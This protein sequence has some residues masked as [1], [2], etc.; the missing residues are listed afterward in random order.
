MKNFLLPF[1]IL[2]FLN[3]S[4]AQNPFITV[5]KTDN[6]GSSSNNRILIPTFGNGYN[7]NIEWEDTSNV[8]I[9]GS[10][11][12]LTNTN[13]LT[14]IFPSPGVYRVKISGDF[15]RIFFQNWGDRE[16]IIN[17]E[18]WGNIIWGNMENA[19]WGCSNLNVTATDVLTLPSN[20]Q[21]MFKSCSSLVGNPSFNNWNTNNVTNMREMFSQASL[22]N[23]PIGNW[24]TQ[25]ATNM[26]EMF[27]RAT[28][29][30]QPINNWNTQ[31]VT[32]MEG[33]FQNAA[34]FNQDIGTWILNPNVVL[35]R[36]FDINGMDCLN[37]SNTLIG[38]EQNNPNVT[39]K[40]LGVTSKLYH[41]NAAQL[42]RSSL[43]Q[44]GWIINGDAIIQN[45]P[46]NPFVTVWKT[47]N[48][49]PSANNQ[50]MIPISS[51]GYNFN[52][53]WEDTLNPSINGSIQNIINL[54]TTSTLSHTLT[55]PSPG[56][57][58][59]K[60]TGSF[61]RICFFFGG[62][63]N[64]ILDVEQWGDISWSSMEDAFYKCYL[65]NVS[66]TDVLNLPPNCSRMFSG[67][68]TLIGNPSFNN[69]NTSNVTN[70][71]K[72]FS[73]VKYFNQ[74]IGNWNTSN[75][76]NMRDMFDGVTY[77]N[78]DISSWNTSNVT[79]MGGMFFRA[80]SFNQDIGNWNTQNV[81]NMSRMFYGASSFNQPIGNWN[82]SNVTNMFRMFRGA[83]TFNQPIGNWNTSNVTDMAE[84]FRGA[85]SF[86]QDIGNWN[87]SNVTDMGSMFA[88]AT[89]F[90]QPIGNWNTSNVTSMAGMFW[91]A[92][93]F[94]QPIGNWNTDN[95]VLLGSMFLY[96]TS[97]N[98]DIGNWN[99]SNVTNMFRVFYGATSFNQDISNWN[100][101]NVNNMG[102]MFANAT[103][104]NCNISNW[105]VSNVTTWGLYHGFTEM[106]QNAKNFN[107]DL[108]SWNMSNARLTNNMF[109]N[110]GLSVCNLDRII[111]HWS[112]QNL[113][114]GLNFGIQGLTYS[115]STQNHI[116]TLI[117]QHNW[118]VVGGQTLPALS[119]INLS[120]L[121]T[122]N[123]SDASVEI[124]FPNFKADT[125][126]YLTLSGATNRIDTS[127]NQINL[128]NLNA[129]NHQ[130]IISDD[131]VC[132]VYTE[133]FTINS[134][135][136]VPVI[137]SISVK[138]IDCQGQDFGEVTL[139]ASSVNGGLSAEWTLD[140]NTISNSLS[141]DSL[142]VGTYIVN[143]IDS[144]GCQLQESITIM[145]PP[146]ISIDVLNINNATCF[147]HN[148][149]FIEVMANG[150]TGEL[151]YSWTDG[152]QILAD[153]NYI[154]NLT[155]ESYIL[156]IID[157][158]GCT[159]TDTFIITQPNEIQI[160]NII[161]SDVTCFGEN[162]GSI[163]FQV[164][165]GVG[166]YNYNWN[167][168]IFT[169]TNQNDL[170]PGNYEV[171]V[172][173]ANGCVNSEIFNINQPDEIIISNIVTNDLT[174]FGGSDGS[175][176]FQVAGGVGSYNYNWIPNTFTGTN[177]NDLVAGNYSVVIEDVDGCQ[178]SETFSINQ[179]DEIQITNLMLSDVTCFGE[180]DGS[181]SFQ[182]TGGAG[183]YNYNWNPSIFT[184]TNQ[185]DLVPG[186]YEVVVEDANGCVNSEIF[187]I[188]QPDEI[189]ISNIL[190][191]DV[192][193]FGE[194]DGSISFQATGGVGSY[195]YNWIPNIFTGT[196]QNNL[197]SGN[198]EVV[199]E[200]ANGCLKSE[201]FSINQPDEIQINYNVTDNAIS[202]SVS[203]GIS[204]Y[205]FNWTGPDNFTA[206]TA[207]IDNL[208]NG[209]YN[210]VVTDFNGCEQ[211]IQINIDFDTNAPFYLNSK[212][213]S[214]YP[215]PAKNF[216]NIDLNQNIDKVNIIITDL[217]GKTVFNQDFENMSSEKINLENLAN[218]IYT[219]RISDSELNN[220]N[221]K[222]IKN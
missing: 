67:C 12:N 101:S 94:N 103:S 76:T 135:I 198:Y 134:N 182:V 158:L 10:L 13:G 1:F 178:K 210:L 122:C 32:N 177:Q 70:M 184:G 8:N 78:Q 104:F 24:N 77:F 64:K 107:Q 21:A 54:T 48:L 160:N 172:E 116:N 152:N 220:F 87:T 75:V 72:M 206:N 209:D 96:A 108:S 90:N 133:N 113:F 183:S 200:D 3:N 23:Q 6:W 5:W 163:S 18:Q 140:G 25:N 7:F 36:I 148:D 149:G 189:I 167:P 39:N 53:Y 73:E 28:L 43:I 11:S 129:G 100:T 131:G 68:E 188:N 157:S 121:N 56:V 74:P 92:A 168:S 146:S 22:F 41:G 196:N 102:Q 117:N 154:E 173:D 217:Y 125:T 127:T 218:G 26:R 162:D 115:D 211:T 17:I 138:N 79:D 105:D 4:F 132:P 187:T 85:T 159:K 60:I 197:V 110:S 180:N 106:F 151:Y 119:N 136:S 219:L 144:S 71:S 204:P 65:L 174:C 35:N 202:V 82:T 57:Y 192:T 51:S 118:T 143:L 42:A 112:Q 40:V 214:I 33:M 179:P 38:L 15:P 126:Y 91:S 190:T 19:F 166:S 221:Y 142:E 49:G 44:R 165:G 147:G 89:S 120:S 97:F 99:T 114:Q 66:A 124:S 98:Q 145:L 30:N 222:I 216:I 86:N 215:N 212:N 93:S 205:D 27:F 175:I 130:L 20:C 55:F 47:D 109:E 176:S 164:T 170:V 58:R 155:A 153:S 69:W 111:Y 191:N 2:L 185:N 95:L 181:I 50:I 88:G 59:V 52:I 16:K 139:L 29:F 150:G 171:V 31:N 161:L 208:A 186:N 207:D 37:Y 9:N 195:N 128:T 203:G 156:N 169:G 46:M 201:T 83:N 61:P 14:V 194:N 45:C 193:C 84:M 80:S 34:S 123:P 81:T 199:V 141:V 137:D 62:D 63:R 213:I